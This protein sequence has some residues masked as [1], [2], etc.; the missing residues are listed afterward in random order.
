MGTGSV[1][2]RRHKGRLPRDLV[3]EACGALREGG[4]AI[5]PTETVYG[6]FASASSARAV[7][8]LREL[9]PATDGR[10]WA[11]WH[12][13]DADGVIGALGIEAPIHRRLIRRLSPGP[14]TY[15][16]P[17]TGERLEAARTRLGVAEGVLDD[18]LEVWARV[19]DFAATLRVLEAAQ[20]PIV[21][22]R[23][24]AAGW[25]DDAELTDAIVDRAAEAGVGFALDAGRARLGAPST[26][27]RL[28]PG[29][30]EMVREGARDARSIDRRLRRTILFVCTGN[31]CR[32]PMAAAIARDLVAK[33]GDGIPTEVVSAG[34]AAGRGSPATPEAI[35]A[36]REVGGDL[37]DHRSR[38]LTVEMLREADV[39]YAMTSAHLDAVLE[40]DSH[41]EARLLDPDGG[42]VP[43]PIGL[44]ASVY[45][46]T[47]ARLRDLI[48]RRLEEIHE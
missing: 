18:G 14:Q 23:L 2:L 22:K 9:T 16:V 7:G 35:E 45:R 30:Y 33:G 17:M 8:L 28:T 26:V 25:G 40:M 5:L 27:V 48:A 42:D 15:S 4:L 43:D 34:V 20:G 6:V 29:G 12:A 21:G 47:A 36:V 1:I 19:P 13:P 10:W 32:S 11:A 46:E 39:V 24:A 3:D 44:P 31:T 37:E 41:A 38:P